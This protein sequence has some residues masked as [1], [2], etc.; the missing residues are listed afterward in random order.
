MA[1]EPDEIKSHIDSTRLELGGNLHELEHRMK[2]VVDWRTYVSKRPFTMVA[3]AFLAG[4]AASALIGRSSAPIQDSSMRLPF[5]NQ[6]FRN[7]AAEAWD[8]IANAM[9]GLAVNEVTTFLGDAMPG[10]R[11]QYVKTQR[12]RAVV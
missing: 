7:R 5:R 10:F 2:E 9:I 6:A 8:N 11:E 1:D 4:M 3:T 12:Q